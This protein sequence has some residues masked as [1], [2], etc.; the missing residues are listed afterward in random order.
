M[1]NDWAAAFLSLL[2][3]QELLFLCLGIIIGL[4]VGVLP[5]LGGTTALVLLMPVTMALEPT[6][7]LALAGGLFGSNT[8]GGAVTA[9][10]LNTPGT[11]SSAVT[12][13]D[14]YPLTQQG[15]AGLAIGAAASSN[16]LGGLIGAFSVLIVIPVAGSLI[17][18]FGPP[19]FFA[20][21]V[22]GLVLVALTARGNM[23]RALIMSCAG[24]AVGTIGYSDVL[25][26]ERF[27]FG[28]EYLWDGIKLPV[29]II[30]LY[31]V[32][33][34]T[35]LTLKG[36]T[37]A[38][39]NAPRNLVGVKEGLWSSFRY[40]GTL[41][42][43]SLIGTV[44]GAIPGVG[45]TVAA[46]LSYSTTAQSDKDP[47]SFGK[48]NIKGV[49]APEAAMTAKD[50]S[51]LIPTL[52]FGIPGSA[53][54]AIFMNILILH[55]MQPGPLMLMHNR[56]EI[57]SLV[58]ALTA[59]C[60]ITSVIGIALARPLTS[61]T[62][63]NVQVLAPIIIA[64]ALIGAYCIDLEIMNVVVA[65]VFGLIG[66]LMIRYNLPRISFVIAALLSSI[67]ERNYHQS[68][69][70]SHDGAWI[71]L[72]RPVCLVILVLMLGAIAAAN[73]HLLN[74]RPKIQPRRV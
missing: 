17:L 3:V 60:M 73:L 25:G 56:V 57:Y 58:W 49:I 59:A 5:G 41:L 13:L 28:T 52:A 6:A 11:T 47:E 23:W 9:I 12:C 34:M 18:L 48:G 72:Q 29:A 69:M 55:G 27:V 26:A 21:A 40:W 24:A 66:Y 61:L 39:A 67:A 14:G 68:I 37:V 10:L 62:R 8:I 4:F 38:D 32:A 44:I 74:F 63:V 33:E 43:G 65:G 19:E 36:G 30:G 45:G 16:A 54:M 35:H 20:L 22:L 50:G 31:A 2:G 42:R 46:F 7:A 53:E 70:M 15:K 71:F 1:L 51:M 64:V